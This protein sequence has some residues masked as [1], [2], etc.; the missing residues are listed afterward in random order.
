M[1]QGKNVVFDV[2]GTLVCYDRLV[3]A[4]DTRLGARL[5]ALN[6]TP[7]HLVNTW[8]EVAEREYTYLSISGKYTPF[9]VCLEQ[10]FRRTL[11]MAGIQ[12]DPSQAPFATPED[13]VYI[14]SEYLHLQM[15]PGATECVAKL[16]Q[17]GFTVWALTAGDRERVWSYFAEA[18]IDLPDAN[19]LSCDASGV[20]KP[21]P[22]AYKPLLGRLLEEGRQP[23]FAAAHAWDAS[24]ARRTGFKA[25]YCLALEGEAIPE[26][27]GEMDVTAETL[28][29]MAEKIIAAD[30][31]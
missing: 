29:A 5:R 30:A 12:Q 1:P 8:I 22:L 13:M 28:P 2:V 26:L 7:L 18:G 21:D 31:A 11:W 17:A 4:I 9:D 15:R 6:I 20:G 10:L 19:M 23:W 25:A 3:A 27:F 16:R 24:A 14:M